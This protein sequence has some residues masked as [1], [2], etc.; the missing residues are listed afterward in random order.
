LNCH[1][2]DTEYD[3]YNGQADGELEQAL[4]HA[5]SRPI[6]ALRLSE[7]ASQPTAAHLHGK[8][9]NQGGSDHNL[10]NK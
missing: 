7:D 9:R 10:G 5:P 4:F 6:D 3:K 8:Y 2:P 1:H